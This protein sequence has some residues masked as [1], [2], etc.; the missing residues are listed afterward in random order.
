MASGVTTLTSNA[1]LN[2]LFR[3]GSYTP[4][5]NYYVALFTV[6]PGYAGGG[7]EVTGGSY[8]RQAIANNASQWTAPTAREISNVNAV[9]FPQA[10]ATWGVV[11]HF[12][13]MDN[14]SGG[15]M[16]AF[17]ALTTPVDCPVGSQR[18]FPAG[19]LIVRID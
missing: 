6:A 15:N 12:G 11:T 7:T 4:V 1:L 10:S 17:G 8:A 5:S 2:F 13:L 19:S 9:T 3:A 18:K 14:L 16:L